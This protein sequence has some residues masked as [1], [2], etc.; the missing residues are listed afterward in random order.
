M[1][2]ANIHDSFTLDDL[3][4]QYLTAYT[5]SYNHDRW[6][7]DTLAHTQVTFPTLP[8]RPRLGHSAP[9][10]T[11]KAVKAPNGT[12]KAVKVDTAA[13]SEGPEHKATITGQPPGK[14]IQDSSG[15]V[16]NEA[17]NLGPAA[18][19]SV[20]VALTEAELT[21]ILQLHKD[22]GPYPSPLSFSLS[23]SF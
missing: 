14:H 16:V 5:H 19:G 2:Y 18:V 15:T 10:G 22:T 1:W 11:N 8:A 17:L 23:F 6:Y 4:T 13:R 9:K 12:N 21:R 20:C 3:L 7:S